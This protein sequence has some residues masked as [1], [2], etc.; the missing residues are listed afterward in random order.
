VGAP[1][2]RVGRFFCDRNLGKRVPSALADNGWKVE[3]HDD[4]FDQNASDD[5]ILRTIAERRWIFLTQDKKIRTRGPE[6]RILLDYGVSTVSIATTANLSAAATV[7]TL[8]AAEAELFQ[9]IRAEPPPFIL[10]VY[11]DGSVR[12]LHLFDAKEEIRASRR[13]R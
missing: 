6:R 5:V 10:A 3:R 1:E 9:A 8:L 11:K 12:R 4:H 7:E 13:G 2:S